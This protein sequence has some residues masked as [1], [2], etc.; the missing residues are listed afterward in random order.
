MTCLDTLLNNTT[1]GLYLCS[2]CLPCGVSSIFANHRHPCRGRYACGPYR[3][4]ANTLS[5]QHHYNGSPW[6]HSSAS[7][8]HQTI[9]SSSIVRRLSTLIFSARLKTFIY[10]FSCPRSASRNPVFIACVTR[11]MS[12]S[13]FVLTGR[14]GIR[15]PCRGERA[16]E[17]RGG[18]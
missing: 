8:N 13:D 15:A 17:D 14:T 12:I 16:G 11:P 3:S 9:P 1:S 5:R 7:G 10:N 4:H 18:A 6:C 2:S